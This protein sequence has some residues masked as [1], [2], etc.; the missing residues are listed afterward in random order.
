VLAFTLPVS[1][2]TGA[3]G[4]SRGAASQGFGNATQRANIS[5]EFRIIREVDSDDAK[6]QSLHADLVIVGPT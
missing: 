1:A 5:F 6:L 4:A 3:G 2:Q